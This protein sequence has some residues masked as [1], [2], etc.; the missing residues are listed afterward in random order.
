[1]SS[2]SSK[3]ST[4]DR[5]LQTATRLFYEQGYNQ[6]GINQIIKE[7]NVAKASLYQHF[8]S[9]EVLGVEY[10]RQVRLVWF[11]KWDLAHHDILEPKARILNAFDFLL[12]SMN[13]NQFRGCRFLN[14]LSD[15]DPISDMIR[16]EIISHKTK[17]RNW[18]REQMA[19]DEQELADTIY[20]LFEGAIVE[21][22]MFRDNWPI[23]TA[24]NRVQSLLE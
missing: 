21:S 8:I 14:L 6:T 4:R 7:A 13:M 22:K 1:M 2:E 11:E 20:L 3:I 16:S 24:K 19:D 12:T 10:I 18:F 23:I 9:K 5:I 15:I 17:L